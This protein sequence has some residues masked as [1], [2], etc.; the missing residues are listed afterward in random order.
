MALTLKTDE[1]TELER[2]VRSRKIRAEDTARAGDSGAREWQLVFHDRSDRAGSLDH[3]AIGDPQ[4]ALE[5]QSGWVGLGDWCACFAL[6]LSADA[7]LRWV[8]NARF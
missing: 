4:P 7:D 1:R 6:E 8:Q 5:Q 2:R 3:A